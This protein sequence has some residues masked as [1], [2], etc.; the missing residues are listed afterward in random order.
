MAITRHEEGSSGHAPMRSRTLS[1]RRM[2]GGMLV[3]GAGLA[4]G[5]LLPGGASAAAPAGRRLQLQ[6]DADGKQAA[7][8][9]MGING[10]TAAQA[11]ATTPDGF[12][13]DSI[14]GLFAA[15]RSS[16]F[17]LLAGPHQQPVT[18]GIGPNTHVWVADAHRL[19]DLR[20]CNVGDV[21]FAATSFGPL[22][23]RVASFVEVN[24]AAYWA[25]VTAVKGNTLVC[26]T[27]S[28]RTEAPSSQ[29]EIQITPMTTT[30]SGLPVAG[31]GIYCVATK[32]TPRNPSRIWARFIE[33][34][35]EPTWT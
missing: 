20:G 15:A 27:A 4:A 29:I 22:G 3:G 26:T 16:S 14:T 12:L 35:P 30:E 7:L 17:V 31:N 8:A 32:S 10:R 33:T 11:K 5:G 34:F 13:P 21:V 2:L 28:R 18:V 1:R 19:G 24:A 6:A 23:G 25:T 9:A